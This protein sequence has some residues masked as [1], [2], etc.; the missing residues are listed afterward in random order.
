MGFLVTIGDIAHKN[1]MLEVLLFIF[2]VLFTC[3]GIIGL[4]P[5]ASCLPEFWAWELSL[6]KYTGQ[7]TIKEDQPYPEIIQHAM[8]AMKLSSRTKGTT[9]LY[10]KVEGEALKPKRLECDTHGKFQSS[11]EISGAT[12]TV[13]VP[14]GSPHKVARTQAGSVKDEPFT[15]SGS[16]SHD[17]QVH[18]HAQ[19]KGQGIKTL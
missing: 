17:S 1:P 5:L 4:L 3:E 14:W 13:D 6:N 11:E 10:K 8:Q 18:S 2:N 9:L 12:T 16:Q 19:N 7:H 15:A